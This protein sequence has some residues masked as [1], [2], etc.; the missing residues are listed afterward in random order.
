MSYTTGVGMVVGS[1]G[2]IS[3]PIL[4]HIFGTGWQLLNILPRSNVLHE[5]GLYYDMWWLIPKEWRSNQLSGY[6]YFI[7]IMLPFCVGNMV[8]ISV[9]VV[10][11]ISWT[12]YRNKPIIYIFCLL[13]RRYCGW[14][15]CGYRSLSLCP[16]TSACQRYGTSWGKDI[17]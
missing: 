10:L 15:L 4:V 6:F 16:Y 12:L 5:T 9:I 14:V 8:F 7:F 11:L 2:W 3:F 13:F 17:F 1:F